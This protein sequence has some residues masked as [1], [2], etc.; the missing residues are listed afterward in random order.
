VKLLHTGC[1]DQHYCSF[2]PFCW[3]CCPVVVSGADV[4]IR[5]SH[6]APYCS[7]QPKSLRGLSGLVGT[8]RLRLS[9]VEFTCFMEGSRSLYNLDEYRIG[10]IREILIGP[11]CPWG[12]RSGTTVLGRAS[13]RHTVTPSHRHTV[14]PSHR[15]TV[16]PSHRSSHSILRHFIYNCYSF[17]ELRDTLNVTLAHAR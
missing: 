17:S 5:N 8:A 10:L 14:T 1:V 15:H 16:T 9:S 3:E 7:P 13:H 11:H 6:T 4:L 12:V 2:R